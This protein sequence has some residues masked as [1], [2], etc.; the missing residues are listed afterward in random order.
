MTRNSALLAVLGLLGAAPPEA[1]AGE[2]DK[3]L[4]A[5]VAFAMFTAGD[6]LRPLGGVLTL[7]YERGLSQSFSLRAAVGGGI[8]YED[9][10]DDLAPGLVWRGQ[11][12]AGLVYLVD[13]LKYVP[14]ATICLGV[15]TRGGDPIET[16]VYPVL[17]IGGGLD[18]LQSRTFS[19][20]G[21][22]RMS[23]YLDDDAAFSLGARATWR[24]SLF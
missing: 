17:E 15:V 11:A 2:D 13:I 24:W 16:D 21:F 18:L 12:V 19:W 7:E 20:G 1:H 14:Y 6:H 4:S 10:T 8:L 5:D 9:G 23:S 22:A 3:A